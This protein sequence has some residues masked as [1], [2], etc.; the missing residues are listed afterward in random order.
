MFIMQCVHQFAFKQ[1]YFAFVFHRLFY[2]SQSSNI[3]VFT[4]KVGQLAIY[5]TLYVQKVQQTDRR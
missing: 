2:Y 4:F 5:T 1:I 3:I